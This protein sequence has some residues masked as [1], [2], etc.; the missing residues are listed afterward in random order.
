MLKKIQMHSKHTLRMTENQDE[1]TELDEET[2]EVLRLTK[3]SY[4]SCLFTSANSCLRKYSDHLLFQ[5]VTDFSPSCKS[6]K[7]QNYHWAFQL[8]HPWLQQLAC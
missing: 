1:G 2:R 4:L 8:V 3:A 7:I 5:V 6:L